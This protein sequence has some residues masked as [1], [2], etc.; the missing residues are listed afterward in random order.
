MIFSVK[1][2][3]DYMQRDSKN[4]GCLNSIFLSAIDF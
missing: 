2:V 1:K 3:S 4:T